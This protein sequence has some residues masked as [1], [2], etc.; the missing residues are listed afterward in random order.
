MLFDCMVFHT[1]SYTCEAQI[2]RLIPEASRQLL[3]QGTK[4]IVTDCFHLLHSV[5]SFA[6]AAS[7]SSFLSLDFVMVTSTIY[8]SDLSYRRRRIS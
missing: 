2:I 4:F 3:H 5:V 8:L 6:K 7:I 1:L